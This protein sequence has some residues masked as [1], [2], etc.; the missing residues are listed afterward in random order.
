MK[1]LD[2]LIRLHRQH[3]DVK[4]VYR[5]TIETH[6][7]ELEQRCHKI[8]QEMKDER[9]TAAESL[10]ARL[11]L[12]AYAER[13]TELLRALAAEMIDSDVEIARLNDEIAEAFQTLKSYELTRDARDRRAAQAQ[14]KRDCNELDEIG[15]VQHRRRAAL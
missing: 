3:L 13:M 14:A 7:V 6:R 5:T 12:S 4:R 10:E 1:G 11:T 8:R 15:A 9:K 2:T